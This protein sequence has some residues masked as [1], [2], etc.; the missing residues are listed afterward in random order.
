MNLEE[1]TTLSNS[2][3]YASLLGMTIKIPE[4]GRCIARLEV[5]DHLLNFMGKPHGAAIFSL[6]DQAFAAACNSLG[7]PAVALQ[8]SISFINSPSLGDTIIAE[9]EKKHLG[10]STGIFQIDVRDQRGNLVATCSAVAY[11]LKNKDQPGL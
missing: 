9:A 8:M 3:S 2:A 7:R 6:A 5:N 4:P 11:Y 1:L 10:K